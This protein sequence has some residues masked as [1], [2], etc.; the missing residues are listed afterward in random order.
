MVLPRFQA[1]GEGHSQ[2]GDFASSD[3]VVSFWLSKALTNLVK[4]FTSKVCEIDW[5]EGVSAHR[6]CALLLLVSCRMECGIMVELKLGVD[7]DG[8]TLECLE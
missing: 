3:G 1:V 2:G 6:V 7:D 8:G 5:R 4:T